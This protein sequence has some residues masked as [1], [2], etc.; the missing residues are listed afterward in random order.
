MAGQ[1]PYFKTAEEMQRRVDLYFL[2]C[3][4]NQSGEHDS[5]ASLTPEELKVVKTV[6]DV[7]PS[8]TGL[9]LA[10]GFNARKS[11]IDYAEKDEFFNTVKK[12]KLR[13]E[14]AIEQRLFHNNATGSIFNLKNNFEWV[15]KV[16]QGLTDKD[17]NDRDMERTVVVLPSKE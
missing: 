15:D 17:G 10:L 6:D 12:A 2:A 9:A 4:A 14:N 16:E 11:L 3:K 1:P 7:Y 5:F 8:V 13:V